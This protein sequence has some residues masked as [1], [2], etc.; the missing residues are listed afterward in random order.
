MSFAEQQLGGRTRR[1]AQGV[2]GVGRRADAQLLLPTLQAPGR[3][4]A[5]AVDLKGLRHLQEA[6]LDHHGAFPSWKSIGI[7]LEILS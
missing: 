1:Q 2:A 6:H 3:P 5:A 7:I 4:A